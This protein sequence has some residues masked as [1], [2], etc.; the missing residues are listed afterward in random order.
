MLIAMRKYPLEPLA[1]LR[2]RQAGEAARAASESVR[3]REEARR[4]RD[5]AEHA[6]AAHASATAAVRAAE[7]EALKR[8]ELCVRDLA[9][10]SAFF[11]RVARE[12]EALAQA[13]AR[14]T[15]GEAEARRGE[16]LAL[17]RSMVRRADAK[18]VDAHEARWDE[19]GRRR[20]E[21]RDEE[22]SAEAWRPK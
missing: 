14:A 18:V 10:E 13:V 6:H 15:E 1:E 22:A 21:A 16:A 7:L 19:E 12:R 20:A 11:L 5:A 3:T 9:S 8:G 4:A 2:R 17:E